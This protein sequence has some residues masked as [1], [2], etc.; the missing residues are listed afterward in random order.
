MSSSPAR[1]VTRH[2]LVPVRGAP[3]ILRALCV[4]TASPTTLDTRPR[5]P[6]VLSPEDQR[7]EA[8][9]RLPLSNPA[10]GRC[11]L[12]CGPPEPALPFSHE[13]GT[14]R[15]LS[16]MCD[17]CHHHHCRQQLLSGGRSF[18]FLPRASIKR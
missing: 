18:M 14:G 2:F 1:M 10:C 4:S 16:I 9:K 11:G 12:L 5:L 15:P 6:V 8:A 17:I 3:R 13:E 7:G